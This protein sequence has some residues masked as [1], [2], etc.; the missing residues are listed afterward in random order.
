[1]SADL[2]TCI[3]AFA[4]VTGIIVG[5]LTG[6]LCEPYRWDDQR[7]WIIYEYA[8]ARPVTKRWAYDGGLFP[9][10]LKPGDVNCRY[11]QM[12]TEETEDRCAAVMKHG[13]SDVEKLFMLNPALGGD[14]S[15]IKYNTPYCTK[16]C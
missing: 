6:P 3:A 2:G 1:M 10:E 9:A 12:V 14:C 5:P 7:R 11:T 4:P 8:D 13:P 15:N 16:G